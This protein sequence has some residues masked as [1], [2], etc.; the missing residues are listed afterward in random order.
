MDVRVELPADAAGFVRRECP[1]CERQFKTIAGPFDAACVHR[2]V[3]RALVH[4]NADE[5][6]AGR[7]PLH[8]PYCGKEAPLDAFFTPQQVRYLERVVAALAEEVRYQQLSHVRRTLSQN[9]YP[10]FVPVP[11]SQP[12]PVLA[13][14][15]DDMEVRAFLCC[16]EDA[17]VESHWRGA[18]HCVRCGAY[19]RIETGPAEGDG[20]ELPSWAGERT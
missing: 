16:A 10:T 13:P 3:A 1:F 11:P 5:A 12:S 19:Q 4:H 6:P 14:E 8:C 18:V 2:R 20:R 17:K 9:P 7:E 15:P